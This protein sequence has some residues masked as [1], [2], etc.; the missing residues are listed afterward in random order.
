[1]LA[2]ARTLAGLLPVLA[3]VWR[4]LLQAFT[5]AALG[6]A[7]V[8]DVYEHRHNTNQVR[9]ESCLQRKL[10]VTLPLNAPCENSRAHA[11]SPWQ[12]LAVVWCGAAGAVKV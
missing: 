3:E 4:A 7:G 5:L 12:S 11:L 9:L 10:K 8:V 2:A 1:M 6:L